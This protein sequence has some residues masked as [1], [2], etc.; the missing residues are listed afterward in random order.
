MRAKPYAQRKDGGGAMM[1]P[2]EEGSPLQ[3]TIG[4]SGLGYSCTT[5]G[6]KVVSRGH[7]KGNGKGCQIAEGEWCVTDG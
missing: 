7:C 3:R 6:K 1:T 2:D 5:A 4:A